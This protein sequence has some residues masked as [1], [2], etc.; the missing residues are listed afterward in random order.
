MPCFTWGTNGSGTSGPSYSG[1][2]GELPQVGLM[3]CNNHTL[4]T[5][6]LL[7]QCILVH[8]ANSVSFS[9]TPERTN[10]RTPASAF[11]AN[12]FTG[13]SLAVPAVNVLV[14]FSQK[15][16]MNNGWTAQPRWVPMCNAGTDLL[17]ANLLVGL[18]QLKRLWLIADEDVLKNRFTRGQ[19][20]R[21]KSR[22]GYCFMLGSTGINRHATS[23]GG[24]FNCIYPIFHADHQFVDDSVWRRGDASGQNTL[25]LVNGG[26]PAA[27]VLM[28]RMTMGFG[29]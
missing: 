24:A 27:A 7:T 15:D 16:F 6:A 4:G 18:S 9:V 13:L 1:V 22:R 14:T 11:A 8:Q 10:T 17:G 5:A 21:R 23:G 25:L 29:V 19:R 3:R 2:G 26:P 28:T 20:S 12:Y